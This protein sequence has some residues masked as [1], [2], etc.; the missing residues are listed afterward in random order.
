[1]SRAGRAIHV[2]FLLTAKM[3][4]AAMALE[5]PPWAFKA[6]GKLRKGFLWKGRKEV[7]GGHCLL[8]WQRVTRPKD[9]GGLG[10]SDLCNLARALR[11][12]WPWLQKTDPNR[13]WSEFTFQVCAVVQSL[14]A[15]A[16]FTR[17]G[18]GANTLFWQDR[19]ING[20]GIK[21]SS[22]NS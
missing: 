12:R 6:I 1:M 3:I 15:V 5:L 21:D 14:M 19:W 2:Q 17:V 20:K 9:M 7:K 13:P 10:I 16:V 22:S 4:Y 18:N 11:A 8:A